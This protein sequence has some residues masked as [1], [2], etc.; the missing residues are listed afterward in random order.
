[1]LVASRALPFCLT[2]PRQ[3]EGTTRSGT[4][5]GITSTSTMRS[6]SGR[7]LGALLA[8]GSRF[9]ALHLKLF[10]ASFLPLDAC[11][12]AELYMDFE[13]TGLDLCLGRSGCSCAVIVVSCVQDVVVVVWRL[14]VG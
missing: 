5:C 10:V 4:R 1:M 8:V 9:C 12:V 13:T 14:P 7:L 6:S 3:C 2:N 11:D